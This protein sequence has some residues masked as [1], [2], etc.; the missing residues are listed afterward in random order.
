MP[1]K[2][3]MAMGLLSKYPDKSSVLS[4]F[5]TGKPRRHYTEYEIQHM[6]ALYYTP[7]LPKS[8]IAWQFESRGYDPEYVM[9]NLRRTIHYNGRKE[10]WKH[11]G[12]Q[13][14]P[15]IG[16]PEV[17]R[18]YDRRDP[19]ATRIWHPNW[20][21]AVFNDH[22]KQGM[23]LREISEMYNI[24]YV[25]LRGVIHRSIF[26]PHVGPTTGKRTGGGRFFKRKG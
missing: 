8:W 9:K 14:V 12:P 16:Q 21:L 18:Y 19:R 10:K 5:L 1:A 15:F 26:D 24:S 17:Q 4:R 13:N 3:L 11:L 2:R 22:L 23:N 25:S 20:A 6:V 7:E